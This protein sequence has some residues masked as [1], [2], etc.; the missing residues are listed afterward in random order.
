MSTVVFDADFH[1]GQSLI[2]RNRRR[3]NTVCCGRRFGKTVMATAMIGET[4]SQGMPVAYYAPTYKMLSDVWRTCKRIYAPV[5]KDVSEQEKRLAFKTGGIAD[6]WSLDA[7]D[8]VRGR[9]YKRGI[10]DEAAM[11]KP[12]SEAW[13]EAI[14]PTLTDYKGDGYFLSTPKGRND[15]HAFYEKARTDE[16]WASFRMPTSANPYIDPAEIESAR[17]D[18]PSIVFQ[19]EYLAEF[20]D[21]QGAL[22]RREHLTHMRANEVP[23]GLK[24]G[25]GVDLAISKTETADYSA[26]AVVGYDK[27]SGRRYVLDMWRGKEGFHDVVKT[28]R[29]YAEKWNPTRINVEAVQYQIAVVQ[30]LLRKTTLPVKA[31]KPD[32]D[33]VARFHS[34]MARYEQLM[35]THVQGLDPEFERELLSFPISEHDDMVDALVYAEL[36]AVKNQ[37]V[38][39]VF[40]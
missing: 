2:I 16:T 14:R 27:D 5:I 22:I 11:I 6:F 37:G 4:V 24:I 26:I 31:V 3:F 23:N 7:Y 17:R 10:I 13:N 34:I 28:I 40:I 1:P 38:G 9:K 33:K 30:E 20:I 39:A 29:Q 19:Q 18:V 32:K 35:V 21:V 8:S 25:M 15:F 36:A 12:L